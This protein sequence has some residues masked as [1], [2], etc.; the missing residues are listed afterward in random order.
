MNDTQHNH[1]ETVFSPSSSVCAAWAQTDPWTRWP[2]LIVAALIVSTAAQGCN[3]RLEHRKKA[4][5]GARCPRAVVAWQVK[6]PAA[7]Y[8]RAGVST[9][10]TG[11]ED[12]LMSRLPTLVTEWAKQCRAENRWQCSAPVIVAFERG[13]DARPINV[14]AQTACEAARCLAAKAA[15]LSDMNF[16]T[17]KTDVC[18]YLEIPKATHTKRKR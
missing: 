5:H 14:A 17:L 2:R 8:V 12:R 9:R 10:P 13:K 15:K 7:P 16:V 3:H 18:L 4:N 6:T 11:Q 1:T